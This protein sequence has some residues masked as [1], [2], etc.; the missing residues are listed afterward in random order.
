[1]NEYIKYF[2]FQNKWYQ[3]ILWWEIRRIPY[4]VIMIISGL[5]SFLI[6]AVSIPFNICDYWINTQFCLYVWMDNRANT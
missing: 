2:D 4:N 3:S 1:M 5:L 6:G